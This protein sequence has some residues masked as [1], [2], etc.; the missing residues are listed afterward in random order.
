MFFIQSTSDYNNALSLRNSINTAL[1]VWEGKQTQK[2]V[3]DFARRQRE[4]KEQRMKKIEKHL[5]SYNKHP[6]F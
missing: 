4:I 1:E 2:P 5:E 3:S 6:Y